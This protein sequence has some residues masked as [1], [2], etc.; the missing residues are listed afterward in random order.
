MCK[1][2]ILKYSDLE[3]IKI[4]QTA[5]NTIKQSWLHSLKFRHLDYNN[6]VINYADPH[7]NSLV[8]LKYCTKSVFNQLIKSQNN[9]EMLLYFTHNT[10]NP[11]I[12]Y[13]EVE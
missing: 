2:K 1:E 4:D 8:D 3:K 7:D 9:I 5:I 13:K 6:S 11:Y 10:N 12:I